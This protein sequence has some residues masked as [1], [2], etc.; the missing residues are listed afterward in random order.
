[1]VFDAGEV[2]GWMKQYMVEGSRG[3]NFDP[4]LSDIISFEYH[5]VLNE[6]QL[7]SVDM[8]IARDILSFLTAENVAGLLSEFSD[9]LA[10]EGAL[11]VGDNEKISFAGWTEHEA[12]GIRWYTVAI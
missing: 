6:S 7:P 10:P 11:I 1:M 2:P 5:D 8:I 12:P 9:K 4:G 3:L